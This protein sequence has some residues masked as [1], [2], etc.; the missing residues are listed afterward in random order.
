M[1]F[2]PRPQFDW[3][4]RTRTVN[5]GQRTIIMG[6]LN[7][8]PD[9]FSDGGHF[10]SAQNSTERALTQAL[11]M[12]DEGATIL[13]IGGE[14]TRPGALPVSAEEE[15][16]RILPV[17]GAV[18]SER[19]DAILSVDTFHATTAQRAIEAGAEIVNDVSGLLWDEAMA[20]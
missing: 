18:L 11:Q 15:Q 3:H 8:T 4:L 16:A 5:L 17:I 9:S 14:S 1:P 12:L 19:P 20:A 2:L 7:V 10:Y 6:I 13:D